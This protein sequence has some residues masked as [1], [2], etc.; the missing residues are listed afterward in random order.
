M[1]IYHFL[2]IPLKLPIISTLDTEYVL[3]LKYVFLYVADLSRNV[4]LHVKGRLMMA[5]HMNV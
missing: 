4:P 1:E 5:I 3:L 2:Y